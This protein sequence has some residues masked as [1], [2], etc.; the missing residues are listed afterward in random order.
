[1]NPPRWPSHEKDADPVPTSRMKERNNVCIFWPFSWSCCNEQCCVPLTVGWNLLPSSWVQSLKSCRAPSSP[2]SA[3]TGQVRAL[4][5]H[6]SDGTTCWAAHRPDITIKTL[7][8]ARNHDKRNLHLNSQRW[9]LPSCSCTGGLP[10]FYRYHSIFTVGNTRWFDR[11]RLYLWTLADPTQGRG[12]WANPSMARGSYVNAAWGPVSLR[13][14]QVAVAYG[15]SAW[16]Y[17]GPVWCSRMGS[18]SLFLEVV[19]SH[20]AGCPRALGEP[21]FD[22]N[23]CHCALLTTESFMRLSLLVI[24]FG[25]QLGIKN[26]V[27]FI[28][29]FWI[30]YLQ[31]NGEEQWTSSKQELSCKKRGILLI[32]LS[33]NT[34][35]GWPINVQL[36]CCLHAHSWHHVTISTSTRTI[37]FVTLSAYYTSNVQSTTLQHAG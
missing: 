11:K 27:A 17:V 21:E 3:C 7:S 16:Q 34:A 14:S 37:G 2:Q 23:C 4:V 29:L 36:I 10:V 28:Q 1:M 6:G 15:A 31:I 25:S 5:V 33:P 18:Q 32:A 12:C 19:I 20:W 13:L 9:F 35:Y 22:W 24:V 8:K 30:L 26:C